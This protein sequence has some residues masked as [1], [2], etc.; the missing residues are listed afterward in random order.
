MAYQPHISDIN[1]WVQHFRDVVAGKIP[2]NQNFYVVDRYYLFIFYFVKLTNLE[3][4]KMKK[5]LIFTA[6]LT[7]LPRTQFSSNIVMNNLLKIQFN[8]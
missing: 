3:S 8:I 7:A 4:G 1:K 2:S 5:I 6:S